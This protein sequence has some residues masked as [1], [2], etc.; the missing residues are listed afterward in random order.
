MKAHTD[1]QEGSEIAALRQAT[2]RA[3]EAAW[4]GLPGLAQGTARHAWITASMERL[5]SAQERLGEAVG[6]EAATAALIALDQPRD[7][8]AGR[9]GEN[10]DATGGTDPGPD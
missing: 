6:P 4:R 8:Q 7:A 5:A 10:R 3:H 2:R 1:L 9:K